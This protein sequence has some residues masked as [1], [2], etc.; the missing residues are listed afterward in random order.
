MPTV[1][2][3][4]VCLRVHMRAVGQLLSYELRQL[5]HAFNRAPHGYKRFPRSHSQPIWIAAKRRP[6]AFLP[7]TTIYCQ[8]DVAVHLPL[9]PP[10]RN[11]SS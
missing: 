6:F 1:Y 11:V 10:F 7:L 2:F 4:A 3:K 5:A 9:L 8:F